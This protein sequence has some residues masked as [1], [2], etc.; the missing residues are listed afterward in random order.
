MGDDALSWLVLWSIVTVIGST[1]VGVGLPVPPIE[2]VEP[3][4]VPE[5]LESGFIAIC[6]LLK[7]HRRDKNAKL[8]YSMEATKLKYTMEVVGE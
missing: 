7:I 5:H 4:L 8:K 1:S 3:A 2:A 6:L